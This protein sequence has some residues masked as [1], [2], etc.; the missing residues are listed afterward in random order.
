MKDGGGRITFVKVEMPG[1]KMAFAKCVPEYK[2]WIILFQKVHMYTH[3][4]IDI[5]IKWKF[6]LCP[7]MHRYQVSGEGF[8]DL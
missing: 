1:T 7:T 4:H 8:G 5:L 3:G 2:S 6:R